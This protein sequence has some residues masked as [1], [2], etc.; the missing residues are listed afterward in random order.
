ME[1]YMK[2]KKIFRIDVFLSSSECVQYNPTR[3]KN[4]VGK[5]LRFI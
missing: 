1:I 3:F 4:Q 2:M 5:S